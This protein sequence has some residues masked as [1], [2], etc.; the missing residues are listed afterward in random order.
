M[1]SRQ[2]TEQHELM[3]E[4]LQHARQK[5]P[6]ISLSTVYRNLQVFKELGLVEEGRLDGTRRYYESA[7]CSKH[8]HM[9][10]LGCGRVFEFTRPSTERIKPSLGMGTPI[11]EKGNSRA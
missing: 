5:S 11:Q 10:C 6:N 3:R 2:S 9:V 8:H 1:L 7:S 4:I